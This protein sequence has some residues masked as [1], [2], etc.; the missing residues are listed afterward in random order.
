MDCT[1]I[2]NNL[3]IEA[4]IDSRESST[5]VTLKD[6]LSSLSEEQLQQ[7]ITEVEENKINIQELE[8]L[9]ENQ[10]LIGNTSL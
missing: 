9:I 4:S 7:L 3:Q 2:I 1:Y 5:I 10:D 6:S 8:E